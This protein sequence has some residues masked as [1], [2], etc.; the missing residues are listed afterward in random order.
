ML[1]R[2]VVRN[3][4]VQVEGAKTMFTNAPNRHNAI[5]KPC[6]NED[7]GYDAQDDKTKWDQKDSE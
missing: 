6:W 2:T 4:F 3:I 1:D 5:N 7:K